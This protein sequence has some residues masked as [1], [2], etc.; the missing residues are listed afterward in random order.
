MRNRSKD[1][2]RQG[3]LPHPH[4]G[5]LIV[6]TLPRLPLALVGA[7][8]VGARSPATKMIAQP[9]ILSVAKNL[10]SVRLSLRPKPRQSHLRGDFVGIDAGRQG[11]LPHP[12]NGFLI[13]STLP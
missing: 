9:V 8:L 3:C 6:S 1:A 7:S 11:C 13:V 10:P 4:N 12:H 2:G 5:F